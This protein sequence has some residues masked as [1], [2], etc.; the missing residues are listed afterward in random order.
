[1]A[2]TIRY[3]HSSRFVFG[4]PFLWR[5]HQF[6]PSAPDHLCPK[7]LLAIPATTKTGFTVLGLPPVI[8]KK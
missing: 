1:M 4:L 5:I 3:S 8:H 6:P 7:A 2:I